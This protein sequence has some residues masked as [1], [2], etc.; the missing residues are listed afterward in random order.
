M[1][2][3]H[4]DPIIDD[5]IRKSLN[6][7]VLDG[8]FFSVMMGACEN[9]FQAFAVFLKATT[10]QTGIVTS[11]PMF[12]G[13]IIQLFSNKFIEFFKSRKKMMVI[14]ALIRT[15]L[16]LPLI[17]VFFM[18]EY[19]VWILIALIA[20]YFI[21]NFGSV[22]AWTSWMGDLVD[23]N[24]R[25]AYFGKR[26]RI[27]NLVSLISV[28]GAGLILDYFE[29]V[30]NTLIGFMILFFVGFIG[31][32]LSMLFLS[33]K[34]DVE[35]EE[36]KEGR[37]DFVKFTRE[38]V[39][40]NRGKFVLYNFL[41]YFGTFFMAP[42]LTPYMLNRLN[43]SY[44]D[45]MV[46]T[47]VVAIAK[48]I[49]MP[50]WGYFGDRYGNKKILAL[51]GLFISVLPFSWIFPRSLFPVMILQIFAGIA[52]AGFDISSL[53]FTYDVTGKGDR[54]RYTTYLQFYRGLGLFAGSLLGG[55]VVENIT[56][57]G[58][59]FIAVFLISGVIRLLLAVPVM[60]FLT[61]LRIVEHTTYPKMM[62]EMFTM[63][64]RGVQEFLVGFRKRKK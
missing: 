31:S 12:L 27:G 7:S 9:Y 51:S 10:F 28:V 16:F 21:L 20:L 64:P 57:M 46:A 18:G 41:L 19:R 48:F 6:Y 11:V 3:K 43:F 32:F 30:N 1:H 47:S 45:F 13:S 15:F 56:F 44:F 63:A 25:G 39:T 38:I 23:E 49:A 24:K 17:F 8:S 42:Y 58:S 34:Y 52:W 2:N 53:N 55:L 5:K 54:T 60:K 33:L 62:I 4:D 61:E 50:M 14:A 22:P 59:G 35:Y 29:M 37:L 40:T 26:N 36:P